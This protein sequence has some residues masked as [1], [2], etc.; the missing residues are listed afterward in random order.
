VSVTTSS[1]LLSG[2][3]ELCVLS[4]EFRYLQ[5]AVAAIT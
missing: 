1:F 2:L 5:G 4:H 3:Y